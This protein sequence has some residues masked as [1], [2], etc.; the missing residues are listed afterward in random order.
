ME[1]KTAKGC[2]SGQGDHCAAHASGK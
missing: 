1:T 2:C